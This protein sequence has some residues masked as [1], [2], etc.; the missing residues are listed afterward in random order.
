MKAIVLDLDGTLTNDAKEITPRTLNVLLAAQAKGLRGVVA[1]GRRRCGIGGLAE[2]LQI[3]RYG[4]YVLAFNGGR[5]IEWG[6]EP[7]VIFDQ[8]LDPALVPPLY[9]AAKD[10]GCE[11]LTYQGEGIAATCVRDKY[12]LH[13]AFI[14]K[15]PVT[16][17]DDF[18][19]QVQYP[20]NKCLIV[21]DPKRLIPLEQSLA[22]AYDGRLSVYRSAAFFLECVPPGIDKAASLSRLIENLGIRR[23]ELI[24]VGDGYNDLSMIRFA[25]LGVAMANAAREVQDAADYITWSNQEDGVAHVVEKFYLKR[26]S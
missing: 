23:E 19:H 16:L 9:Q 8:T 20:I 6:S 25:G 1:A 24:A 21:G 10:A 18:V 14:N 3:G 7:R 12:V 22:S 2:R 13:E 15:M 4:G 17:Y 5:V 11:I 26:N